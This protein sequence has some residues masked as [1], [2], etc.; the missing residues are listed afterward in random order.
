M[1]YF[2]PNTTKSE[3]IGLGVFDIAANKTVCMK[4]KLKEEKYFY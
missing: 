4:Q 1:I 2:Y 3:T